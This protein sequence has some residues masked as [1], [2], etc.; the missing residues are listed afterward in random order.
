V[1][2]PVHFVGTVQLFRWKPLG[3]LL[4]QCGVIAV[5]RVQDDRRAMRS[6]LDT[7]EAVY[8]VLE[9]GDAVAIF[10]EGITHNDPQ[11]KTVKTGAARMA[12]ELEHRHGGRLGLQI[13]PVGLTFTAK[14]QYRSDALVCFG[15]PIP[16]ATFLEGY[17]E[18]QK[19]CI[20]N[21]NGRIEESIQRL[22]LHVPRLEEARVVEAV[23]RLYLER[24][25]LGSEVVQEPVTPRAEEL[26]LTRA[27]AR[28]VGRVFELDPDRAGNFVRK[29]DHY[30]RWL[31]RLRLSEEALERDEGTVKLA[32]RCVSLGAV[33]VLGLPVAL[34]GGLHRL[35]PAAVV[36]WAVGRF[37]NVREHRP[38]SAM[39][40]ILAGVIVFPACYAGYLLLGLYWLG[41]PAG[42]WYLLSLPVSGLFAHSYFREA[43]RL[44]GGLRDAWV[45]LRARTARRRLSGWRAE[46]IDEI[47]T[48]RRDYQAEAPGAGRENSA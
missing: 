48:A 46:L 9:A 45:L 5:N 14:E 43:R 47:E 23:K 21:L 12:L 41:W 24:L 2:R 8:R 33:A 26:L 18:R 29:L 35:L 40:A 27:I 1:P 20:R 10:P 28:A 19:D 42:I 4:R 30:E 15:E 38:R 11:L 7:F 37:A 6:V 22:M 16:V 17:E 3:W 36:R 32:L 13:V 31:K 25:R 44:F 34:Y 39:V